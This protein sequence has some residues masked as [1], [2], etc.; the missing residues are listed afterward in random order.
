MYLSQ[1]QI[2][3]YQ[4][5]GAIVIKDIFKDWI[6]PLRNGFQTVLDNPSKHGRENV[7]KNNGRFFEDYCNWERV[8]EFK[9]CMFNSVAAQIV[10]EATIQNQY[11]FFMIIFL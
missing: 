11:K 10:A 8:K 9:N 5:N 4:K 2:N 6:E 7:S 3:D 1:Q